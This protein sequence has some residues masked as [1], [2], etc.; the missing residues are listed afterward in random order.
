MAPKKK[1]RTEHEAD[2]G[3][4]SDTSV[5]SH[6]SRSSMG[7]AGSRHSR[8]PSPMAPPSPSGSIGAKS[9]VSFRARRRAAAVAAAGAAAAGT[10]GASASGPTPVAVDKFGRPKVSGPKDCQISIALKRKHDS[11]GE[12]PVNKRRKRAWAD[13]TKDGRPRCGACRQ[14]KS[15]HVKLFPEMPMK[16]LCE[17]LANP[18]EPQYKVKFENGMENWV[19]KE[20]KKLD[21]LPSKV[22]ADLQTDTPDVLAA[23]QAAREAEVDVAMQKQ[24][25]EVEEPLE[26]ASR[27]TLRADR[28]KR[29]GQFV[30]RSVWNTENPGLTPAAE[31][32]EF[33]KSRKNPGQ[34]IEYVKCYRDKDEERLDFSEEEAEEIR[35]DKVLDD[36][37]C[38]LDSE[39][40][41]A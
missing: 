25:T 2:D 19:I 31:D 22:E 39:Q 4:K 6:H 7:S 35:N 36:G 23:K 17:K 33:R 28:A 15:V 10:G 24:L 18:D 16:E 34:M 30:M 40:A 9:A 20:K 38:V 3:Y 1:A 27:R 21:D 32:I 12:C 29:R 8:S 41:R 37:S 26:T 13:Y 11:E 5:K 14:C